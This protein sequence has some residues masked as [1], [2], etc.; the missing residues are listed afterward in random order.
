MRINKTYLTYYKAYA[1]D[2]AGFSLVEA[3]VFIIIVSVALAG[4]LSVMTF[5]TRHSADPLVRKQAIAIAESLIE[6]I[7]AQNFNKLPTDFAG[8]YTQANRKYFDNVSDYNNYTRP[9]GIYYAD[10]SSAISG[11]SGYSITT[12]TVAPADLGP[13]ANLIPVAL[14]KA[15][16]ITV[17]VTGPDGIPL[18]L[19]A[20]RTAYG[21]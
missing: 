11:L 18:T 2:T 17:T 6:E 19:S 16:L 14:D 21:N 5:T 15:R 8:P 1:K 3:I 12:V 10:N 7:A 13:A 20:Y 4:V 9:P